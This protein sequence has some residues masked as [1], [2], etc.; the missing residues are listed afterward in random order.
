MLLHVPQGIVLF[1]NRSMSSVHMEQV[2]RF[3]DIPVLPGRVFSGF[4]DVT[5]IFIHNL[6]LDYIEMIKI[7]DTVRSVIKNLIKFRR[8][9]STTL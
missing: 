3:L 7:L 8:T 6:I 2:K 9:V 1:F 5:S 4:A